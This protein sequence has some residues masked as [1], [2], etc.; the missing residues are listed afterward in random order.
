M[1]NIHLLLLF[2]F[3]CFACN[4][5]KTDLTQNNTQSDRKLTQSDSSE[6]EKKEEKQNFK[7][8]NLLKSIVRLEN[9]TAKSNSM[10][11]FDKDS[12]SDFIFI[13]DLFPREE[14]DSIEFYGAYDKLSIHSKNIP[15]NSL[16]IIYLVLRFW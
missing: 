16:L 8:L 14:I 5:K 11:F 2:I 13:R 15:E 9:K 4:E 6:I 1:K 12:I 3:F 10:K 7:G